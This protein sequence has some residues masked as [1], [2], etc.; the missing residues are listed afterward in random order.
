MRVGAFEISVLV[1]GILL[2]VRAEETPRALVQQA[3]S[4]LPREKLLGV[5]LNGAQASDV[6]G[7]YYS[8]YEQASAAAE[9]VS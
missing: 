4:L 5:V 9:P 7:R 8:S 1:D 2:V 3:V 6:T